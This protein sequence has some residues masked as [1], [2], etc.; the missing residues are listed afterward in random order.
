MGL[1]IHAIRM[2]GSFR[3][4]LGRWELIKG[5]GRPGVRAGLQA[6]DRHIAGTRVREATACLAACAR[7]MVGRGAG[8]RRGGPFRLLGRGRIRYRHVS[9][10]VLLP[11]H[12]WLQD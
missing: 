3:R 11:A 10:V 12:R 6:S 1:A 2:F 9:T 8:R 5:V 7:P 4:G